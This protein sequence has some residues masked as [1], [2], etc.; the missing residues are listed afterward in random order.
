LELGCLL[1][2]PLCTYDSCGEGGK[3]NGRRKDIGDC[4]EMSLIT[5][6]ILDLFGGLIV[7]V[8]WFLIDLAFEE[9]KK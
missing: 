3:K 1:F 4:E 6:I 8:A 9:V 5:K 7:G 2:L